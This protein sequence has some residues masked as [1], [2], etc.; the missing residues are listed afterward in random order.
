MK[1][2]FIFT[3]IISTVLVVGVLISPRTAHADFS[4][5]SNPS[6]YEYN[7]NAVAK[8]YIK[9]TTE[10]YNLSVVLTP[11]NTNGNSV[12]V[13][14][15][16][17]AY[18]TDEENYTTAFFQ[19]LD[20]N[21]RYNIVIARYVP[22]PSGGGSYTQLA[23]L[24]YLTTPQKTAAQ[25][26]SGQNTSTGN[27]REFGDGQDATTTWQNG[28]GI[29]KPKIT[30]TTTPAYIQGV[31]EGP[32][33]GWCIQSAV[34]SSADSIHQLAPIVTYY[35]ASPYL[36]KLFNEGTYVYPDLN[37]I[38]MERRQNY[39][40]IKIPLVV[41]TKN[42]A[43]TS[44]NERGSWKG[45]VAGIDTGEI[46]SIEADTT[47]ANP[48]FVLFNK[49]TVVST[50]ITDITEIFFSF[51]NQDVFPLSANQYTPTDNPTKKSPDAKSESVVATDL[52]KFTCTT[53]SSDQC[54][55]CKD[56][57]VGDGVD[58][59]FGVGNG[60]RKADRYG[61][62]T[63]GDGVLDV[64]PDPSCFSLSATTEAGD[65]ISHDKAGKLLGII[66]CTDKCTFT[67]VFHLLN[68]VIKFFFKVI[69]VPIILIGI[70][71]AGISYFGAQF[72]AVKK[73]DV[74]AMFGHII[75]GILLILCAWLIVYSLLT[76]LGYTDGLI[77][78]K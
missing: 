37:A 27:C 44:I 40:K 52:T 17:E 46:E 65:S 56:N 75:V 22:N 15:N 21:T 20:F 71:W 36:K 41:T 77:F 33:T 8:V 35:T 51:R 55:D 6:A 18:K 2:N 70:V 31:Y 32:E 47:L 49:K 4:L 66:P 39:F 9:S 60:D 13:L 57:Q 74:K 53:N 11:S 73:V 23:S 54:N 72:N 69:L 43:V 5:Y 45:G 3:A 28:D 58:Y 64:E 30:L 59:G 68:N 63:D 12:G 7:G 50:G 10:E 29:T 25:N 16:F 61:I 26:T 34:N 24:G 67:D 38:T 14:V 1:R 76:A 78:L 42:K 48:T 19:N 62:D